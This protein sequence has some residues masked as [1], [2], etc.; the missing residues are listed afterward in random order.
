MVGAGLRLAR[1]IAASAPSSAPALDRLPRRRGGA[2]ELGR[3]GL[4]RQAGEGPRA[5]LPSRRRCPYQ[6]AAGAAGALGR[7]L[8]DQA[9]GQRRPWRQATSSYNASWRLRRGGC[10]RRRR[11]GAGRGGPRRK[12]AAQLPNRRR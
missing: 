5:S 12:V 3:R 1:P 10:H 8:V 9:G 7:V 2:L 4:L 11:T 6:P